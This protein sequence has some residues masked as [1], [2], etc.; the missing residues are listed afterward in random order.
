MQGRG[1]EPLKAE[2]AGLQPAPFGHS[3]T[4]ARERHCSR[5]AV[6]ACHLRSRGGAVRRAGRGSGACRFGG[7]NSPRA[8]AARACCSST[9][10]AFLATSRAGVGSPVARSVRCPAR[11]MRG[12][13]RRRPLRASAAVRPQLR[14]HR[15]EP[16]IL[17]T[18][19]KLDAYLADQAVAEGADLRDDSRVE[20]L[21]ATA[22]GVEATV[23]GHR[24]SAGVAIGADGANGSLRRRS[25]SGRRSSGRRAGGERAVGALDRERYPGRARGRARRRP[26]RLR[27][28]VPEGRPRESR[29]RRLGQRG[30]APAEPSGA[31]A[32]A[33]GVAIDTLTDVKA[34]GCRCA[35]S[36]SVPAAGRVLLVGDAAGLVDRFRV[37]ALRGV[38]LRA[39]R[40]R[41]VWRPARR[42]RDAA[43]RDARP[44]RSRVVGCEAGDGPLR[45][46][47][48]LGSALSGRVRCRCWPPGRRSA[49][50]E[51]GARA[52][53]PSLEAACAACALTEPP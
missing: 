32:D 51:R 16:M 4:P 33:H 21:A 52:R 6:G 37:T 10:L 31:L 5:V 25:V 40:R 22:D 24:V 2:P 42:V 53:T 47:L 15:H 41:G 12:R 35:R 39:P 23:T 50:S 9:R 36:A 13:A 8:G 3:G 19:R 29:C 45:D 34:T 44:P 28:G 38:C 7:R 18:R 20:D 48:F 14:A 27:L 30:P 46:G 1:F 17:M 49:A 26:R 43:R 11:S